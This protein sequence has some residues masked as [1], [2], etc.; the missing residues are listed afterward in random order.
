MDR[1][2]PGADLLTVQL[3]RESEWLGLEVDE[4]VPRSWPQHEGS[5]LALQVSDVLLQAPDC[6]GLAPPIGWSNSI[7]MFAN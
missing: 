5:T 7:E 3:E 6:Y 2:R 4:R 1:I